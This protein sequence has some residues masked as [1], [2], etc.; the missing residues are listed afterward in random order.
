MSD[1]GQNLGIATLKEEVKPITIE[2]SSLNLLTQYLE[3][4]NCEEFTEVAYA[5]YINTVKE[6]AIYL[7]KSSKV[8]A[9]AHGSEHINVTNIIIGR[10]TL[11]LNKSRKIVE[12]VGQMGILFMGIAIPLWYSVLTEISKFTPL[13]VIGSLI[14]LVLGLGFSTIYFAN[15][16]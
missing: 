12:Y 10:S 4:D 14:F 7:R 6:Y 1:S 16:D 8:S 15:K 13:N 5:H 2:E 11:Q 9:K 3:R